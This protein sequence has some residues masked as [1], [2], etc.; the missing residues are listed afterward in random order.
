M[1]ITNGTV[2]TLGERNEI[3]AHGAVRIADGLVGDVGDTAQLRRRYPDEEEI[4][5]RGQLVMPGNICAHTHFYG[6][7]SR[8]LGIPGAAPRDFPQILDKLWWRL[9]R[10][11]TLE[12]VRASALVCLV[13]AIRHGTTTLID[14]HASPNAI[15]GSLDAIADAVTEAGVRASLCYE[16]SDRDGPEKA[17]AGIAENVRFAQSLVGGSC[18]L[19]GASFGLHA[20]MTLSDETL[21]QCVDAARGAGTGF[22]IHVAE[23]HADQEDSLRRSGKRVVERLSDAGILGPASILVH[24]V[25]VDAWELERIRD[26]GAWVTH[27]PRSNMNNAVGVAP[28]ETMLRGGIRVCLGNDGFSN[29]MWAEWKAAY[30]LHK[31]WHGDP[32]RMGGDTVMRMAVSNNAALARTFWPQAALGQLAPGAHADLILV[33]YAPFTALTPGNLPWHVLFGFEASA[34]TATMVAGKWLMYERR[35]LTLDEDAIVTRARALSS[36]VW[37]RYAAAS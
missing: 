31:A 10:A 16:V 32:R 15:D 8:G 3:I 35:L 7:F 1:L 29:N 21:A 19:L 25:D 24:C 37:R 30:L 11:L 34:V 27:Q 36:E 26:S 12:D 18:P 20:S 5:A 6:A 9:D 14:H 22:H 23:G 17:E 28:V 4:D 2:V 33:D 13:D